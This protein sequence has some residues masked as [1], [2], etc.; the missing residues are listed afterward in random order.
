[1]KFKQ[2]LQKWLFNLV[3]G[4]KYVDVRIMKQ[5]A[6]LNE[7]LLKAQNTILLLKTENQVLSAKLKKLSLKSK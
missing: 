4:D 3:Q 5:L 2:K 7:K 1:M 6:E